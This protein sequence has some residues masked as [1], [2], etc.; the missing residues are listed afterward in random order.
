MKNISRENCVKL[1]CSVSKL[2]EKEIDL[3]IYFE[4][5][6]EANFEIDEDDFKGVSNGF[7]SEIIYSITGYKVE[8]IGEV[9]NLFPCPCCGFKT[10]TERYDKNEGTGYDI[11]SYCR[12]EDD[13]TVDIDAYRS[14]NKGSIIDYRKEICRNP[15]KYY[16]SKWIKDKN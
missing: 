16:T 7:L 11:C 3:S 1:I 12:W 8:V 9:E 15:N 6:Q 14:I 5:I 2:I 4:E 10:L 13:G